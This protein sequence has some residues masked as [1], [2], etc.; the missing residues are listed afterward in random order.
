M[1]DEEEKQVQRFGITSETKVVY[2]YGGFRYERLE[3]VL[4]YA[5]LDSRRASAAT[6]PS[7][8]S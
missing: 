7:V 5:E 4:R 8:A 2:H 6:E 3:D 1:T